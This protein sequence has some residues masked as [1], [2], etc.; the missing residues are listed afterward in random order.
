MLPT[1]L[2]SAS[3]RGD[4]RLEVT[5][6]TI[7]VTYP[8]PG[9]GFVRLRT[10]HEVRVRADAARLSGADLAA[11]AGDAE[12]LVTLVNDD[13][14]EEVFRSCPALRIVANVGVGVDNVDLA[15]AGRAGVVVT[16]TPD[17]LTEATAD[18]TWAL[19][20]AVTR[21]VVEGDH[22]MREGRFGG[23]RLDYLLGSGLQGKTLGVI[24]M[25]RI[26]RAVARRA[27]A[28]GMTVAY[29]DRAPAADAQAGAVFHAG[30]ETL[31][32][33]SQVL[34]IHTPLTA[35]T[36]GLLDGRRL[37]L[38]PAGAF[39]VNT[40]RGGIIDEGALADLLEAG[41]LGGAG[42]DVHAD[43]PRANARLVGRDDVVLLPHLGSATRETRAA[44]ADL[45]VENV[46]CVLAG[47]PPLT[48]VAA[49]PTGS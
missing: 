36:R 19:I 8:L 48:P 1:T 41:R 17:V 15:A 27:T 18:L 21:R 46:L 32:P 42:L 4:L 44:M 5:L 11:F 12:A 34:T 22:V 3:T 23:W 40:A 33:T 39:V 16:N 31:L 45:A 14:G 10:F 13:V 35:A 37:R 38:L 2:V 47:R 7:A 25:G 26:G 20:L 30:V 24:G 43:E 49:G 6:A 29:H 9:E 28:F